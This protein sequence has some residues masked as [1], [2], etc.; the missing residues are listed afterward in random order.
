MEYLKKDLGSYNLHI[1]KTNKFKTITVRVVFHS[2]IIKEEITMRNVLCD[3]FLQSS[4]LYPTKKDLTIKAQDLYAAEIEA[5]NSRLG[6]Y[7]TTNFYLTVL[8][9]KYTEKNNFNK[10]VEFLSEVIFNPDVENGNFQSTKLDIVKNNAENSINSL[11]EDPADYALVRMAE[12]FNKDCPISYRMCGYLDDLE[13]ITTKNLYEYYTK[14]INKDFVDIFVIGDV[15]EEDIIPIIKKHFKF[16][17]VKRKKVPYIINNL[18]VRNRRLFAKETADN[19]QSK[20][21]ICNVLTGLTPYERNYPLTLYNIILGGGSDSK[22][23][24]NVR[25]KNSLCYT[26]HSV[27]N[28]LDNILLI[29]AGID[30]SNI[31]KAL[32]IID[33][34]MQEMRKGNFTDKDILIA[35]EYFNTAMDDTLESPSRI[36]DNYLMMELLGTDSIEDKIAKMQIVTKKDII[37]V[38]KKIKMDTV[39]SLEGIKDEGN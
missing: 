23:F 32:D 33:K 7:I 3:M 18:K 27:P 2:P 38:A 28:K 34:S 21:A 39:F 4:K 5:T 29:M 24:K 12:A 37:K 1:I 6:N 25:E 10:A 9:D 16:K 15:L 31:K 11:K 30:K 26:I 8:N 36:I 13:K 19:S 20:L 14:F 17:V 35:K 22:L